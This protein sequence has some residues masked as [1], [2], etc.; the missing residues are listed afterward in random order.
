VILLLPDSTLVEGELLTLQDV[1]INATTLARTAGNNGVETTGLELAL[2][3][4][5]DL[6]LCGETLLLLALNRLAL[7]HLLLG[8]LLASAAKGGAVVGLVPLTEWGGID[9]DDG[10]LG[11][12]VGADQ[13]VVR[14][15]ESDGDDT[16]FA[17]DALAAPGEVA[18]IETERAELA[19]AATG[20]DEVDTLG[21]DTG[22]GRLATLLES[23]VLTSILM[24]KRETIGLCIP[25]LAVVCALS[26]GGAALVTR[27]TRDTERRSVTACGVVVGGGGLDCTP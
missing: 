23:S 21:S 2:E 25:L 13:L 19:V 18:G 4:G 6:A 12:G 15:V 1:T 8:L 7:L 27:I 10:G 5:L 24:F 9:L 17:G 11:E 3:G 20:A 22:V 16:D 14:R 26:T